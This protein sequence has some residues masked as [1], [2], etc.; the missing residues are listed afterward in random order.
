MHTKFFQTMKKIIAFLTLLLLP[1]ALW[2][3]EADLKIPNLTSSQNNLLLSGFVVCFLGLAFGLYQYYKV[4]GLRAHKSMLDVS[5]TIFETCKTYL[6]QQGKFLIIL[7]LFIAI[8]IGFYF[9]YL[10][11]NPIDLFY[12]SFFCSI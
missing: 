7:E 8:C 9:G 12:S 5:H 3:S 10:K 4:K 1:A 6:I 2:A 11:G